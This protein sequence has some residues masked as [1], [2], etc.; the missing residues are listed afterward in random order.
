MNCDAAVKRVFPLFRAFVLGG[1]ERG[2]VNL[3]LDT[4]FEL[5]AAV[6]SD[7]ISL[8]TELA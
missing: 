8:D 3:L 1:Q 2:A 4:L 7:P 6:E 5:F